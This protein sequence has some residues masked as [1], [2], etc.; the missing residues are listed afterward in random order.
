[1]YNKDHGT[2][3]KR[4]ELISQ[5]KFKKAHSHSST[6][7]DSATVAST[8]AGR[9]TNLPFMF[10]E[11]VV[12][13]NSD[14]KKKSRH[15]KV[16]RSSPWK[17]TPLQS[18]QMAMQLSARDRRLKKKEQ[19]MIKRRGMT[20]AEVIQLPTTTTH[21][22]VTLENDPLGLKLCTRMRVS[23]HSRAKRQCKKWMLTPEDQ[24]AQQADSAKRFRKQRKEAHLAI[25]RGI[26]M[27][28]KKPLKVVK[29]GIPV[30]AEL[31]TPVTTVSDTTKSQFAHS[32]VPASLFSWNNDQQPQFEDEL[33]MVPRRYQE[34]R[35]KGDIQLFHLNTYQGK[36]SGSNNAC[37]TIV[38]L[39]AAHYVQDGGV[40]SNETIERV[41]DGEAGLIAPVLRA[42]NGISPHGFMAHFEVSQY[43]EEA[44]SQNLPGVCMPKIGSGNVYEMTGNLHG[45]VGLDI[46]VHEV[47]SVTVPTAFALYYGGHKSLI[48]AAP[49]ST[50]GRPPEMEFIDSM[51]FDDKG[52]VRFKIANKDALKVFLQMYARRNVHDEQKIAQLA[53]NQRTDVNHEGLFSAVK[54]LKN[55]DPMPTVVNG[56]DTNGDM[57]EEEAI[58]YAIAS[59]LQD[60]EAREQQSR[61]QLVEMDHAIAEELQAFYNKAD[62]QCQD[63]QI[64]LLTGGYLQT[65]TDMTE[66][67][68][69]LRYALSQSMKDLSKKEADP[70]A[71]SSLYLED[72]KKII[73]AE[74][75]DDA[76]SFQPSVRRRSLDDMSDSVKFDNKP[77]A[78]RISAW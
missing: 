19:R 47:S 30:A 71:V 76:A 5:Y 25:R 36:T 73:T 22:P 24:L 51:K 16:R 14:N 4:E 54:C 11:N 37:A 52:A 8:V 42:K 15:S 13:D 28:S 1:M 78:K 44:L 9:T 69:A 31:N 45:G 40:L 59:S 72:L 55:D 33:V 48:L 70:M 61:N 27:A 2:C 7:Y 65:C 3:Q 26:V 38:Y 62:I 35:T 20:M 34:Y 60:E 23:K 6:F 75:W 64:K 77:C 49:S 29:T 58:N 74:R 39:G 50:E 43:L 63:T 46:L 53:S 41:I 21:T 57:T 10:R 12:P 68:M 17:N 56:V 32:I 66:E 18:M 67:D